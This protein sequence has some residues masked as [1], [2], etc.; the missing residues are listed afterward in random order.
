MPTT[1]PP[2]PPTIDGQN[3]LTISRF[4][5]NPALVQRRLRTLAE[6]RFIADTVLQGRVQ[7]AGGAVQYEQ[8]ESIFPAR[9]AEAVEPGAKFPITTLGDG[10]ALIAA[11]RKWGL[12][13][14]ITDES[15]RRQMRNPVDRAMTKL[16]NGIV[17]QV[18]T[19]ALA[20]IQAAVTA[21]FA[22]GTGWA[23]ST[24]IVYDIMHSVGVVRALNQGF[25]P[26]TL[27]IDDE[28]AA[29]LATNP[30]VA[31]LL[32]REDG[33]APVYTGTLGRIAGVDVLVSANVPAATEGLLIDRS[34]LGG[35]ADEVPLTSSSMREENGPAVVEG[36]VLRAKRVTVPFVNEPQAGIRL[37]GI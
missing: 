17:K 31:T 20:A 24:D 18:D 8:N 16:V 22:V 9:T 29:L 12:D 23:T 1:Y 32:R 19:I 25:E 26:D 14:I 34:Q 4:L 13:A 5:N 30:T 2:P 10:P 36:W 21:T 27:V 11:V 3:F 37:T 7:A 6:N 35:L 15:V 28:H 33:N